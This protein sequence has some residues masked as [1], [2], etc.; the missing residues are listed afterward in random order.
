MKSKRC[1]IYSPI[2]IILVITLLVSACGSHRKTSVASPRQ[3]QPDR[4]H[5]STASIISGIPGK[6]YDALPAATKTLLKEADGWLGVP[7]AFGGTDK[8]KGV[9]C[10]GLTTKVY[11]DAFSIKLPRNSAEQQQWCEPLSFDAMGI[12]DLVFFSSKGKRGSVG[13]VGIY[14]G[15]GK[16]IHSSS[17]KG[18]IVS[19][20]SDSYYKRTYHSS[21]RVAKYYAL[22]E[23]KP[24]KTVK[25]G[26]Q[27]VSEPADVFV[28]QAGAPKESPSVSVDDLD[29]LLAKPSAKPVDNPRP[30]KQEVEKQKVVAQM[31]T[32]Q[33][34]TVA[35]MPPDKVITT[36]KLSASK[37]ANNETPEEARA[38]ALKKLK[39][40]E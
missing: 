10:S 19:D 11:L 20:L 5:E 37:T 1:E 24:K 38:R 6:D 30:A 39:T 23:Q 22:V 3:D 40:E 34:D 36:L 29:R 25:N 33:K 26:R 15:D 28:A 9:D 35:T 27:R 31:K 21:G 12:G 7:Y 32:A 17:S 18:V 4:S 2:L 8:R 13:H 16:M 14:V